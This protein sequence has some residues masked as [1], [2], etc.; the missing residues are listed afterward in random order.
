M[1]LRSTRHLAQQTLLVV[2]LGAASGALTAG[3][4]R[5]GMGTQID[6]NGDPAAGPIDLVLASSRL[7]ED[8]M[9]NVSWESAPWSDGDPETAPWLPYQPHT[10]V[11]ITHPLGREPVGV[12]V[13]IS[14]A[15]DGATPGLA[16]GELARIVDVTDTDVT[17]WNDTNGV[18]FA[19]IVIF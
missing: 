8:G 9:W 16:A 1:L 12:L 6:L 4:G 5:P 17:V 19:R 13:Y 3:C 10:L 11:H 2:A 14:F 7:V 15:Q 18:Y